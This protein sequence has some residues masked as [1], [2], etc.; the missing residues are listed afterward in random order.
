MKLHDKGKESIRQSVHHIEA[1]QPFQC[2]EK[3]S[4]KGIEE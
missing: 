3:R 4:K 2:E 1:L